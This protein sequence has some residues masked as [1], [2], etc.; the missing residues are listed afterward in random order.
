MAVVGSIHFVPSV[1]QPVNHVLHK[2]SVLKTVAPLGVASAQVLFL[3]WLFDFV[4]SFAHNKLFPAPSLAVV[5]VVQ[6]V[7]K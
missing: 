6:S 5:T 4:A 3:H 7:T 2:A 1:T